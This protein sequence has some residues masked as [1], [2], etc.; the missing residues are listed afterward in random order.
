MIN[1]VAVR[2]H[3]RPLTPSPRQQFYRY[4]RAKV[5]KTDRRCCKA[6]MGPHSGAHLES[7][8]ELLYGAAPPEAILG[9]GRPCRIFRHHRLHVRGCRSPGSQHTRGGARRL[10]GS[11]LRR[12]LKCS[13]VEGGTLPGGGAGALGGWRG[14][15]RGGGRFQAGSGC[16]AG[17][18]ESEGGRVR[19]LAIEGFILVESEMPPYKKS[20]GCCSIY[21]CILARSRPA[22]APAS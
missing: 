11:C 2:Y 1:Q 8:G 7:D 9:G 3:P 10:P 14:R 16:R 13:M 18:S 21:S 20:I 6:P 17:R 4:K 15:V 5:A 22:S 12:S 19:V